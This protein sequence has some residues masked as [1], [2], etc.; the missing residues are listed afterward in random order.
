MRSA[1]ATS[2]ALVLTAATPAS[3]AE[4]AP[5]ITPFDTIAHGEASFR[6]APW[7]WPTRRIT[8]FNAARANAGAVRRAV[9]AWNRSGVRLRFVAVPRGRARVLIR[10][11]PGGGCFPGGAAGTGFDRRTGRAVRSVVIVSQPDPGQ[12]ACSR[13]ALT[14]VVPHELGHVLGLSHETRHCALMNPTL[15]NLSPGRC[16]PGPLEPWRWRCRILE[17]DDVRGAVRIYGG[18]VR[19]RGRAV[20]DVFGPPYPPGSLTAAPD[21][22]GGLVVGFVRPPTRTP[23]A[24]LTVGADSYVVAYRRDSCPAAP[25]EGEAP[26]AE[27]LWTVPEGATQQTT[28]RPA[29]GGRYCIA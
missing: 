27:D 22:L 25:D 1:L 7:R 26:P 5:V 23:P 20:C 14:M 13:W 4:A 6:H 18:R 28:R 17:P 21:S 9:R 19:R 10:Y 29:A 12:P 11:R 15:V 2:L 8:Y 24:F 16:R 3:S